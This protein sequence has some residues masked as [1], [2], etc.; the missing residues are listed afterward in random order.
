MSEETEKKQGKHLFQPGQS[1]NP[2]GRPKGARSKLQENFLAVL[3]D[4]FA[5]E[6]PEAVRR[7][8]E[9]TPAAYVK[10]IASLMPK[11]LEIERPLTDLSDDELISAVD[12]LRSF[13]AAQEVREGTG[14]PQ[15]R[16]PADTVQ[17]LH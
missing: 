8:R 17:A 13:L 11:T 16:E 15:G 6:G 1:G 10:A 2:A 9:E 14:N 7:M 5:A 4:D 12:S 3:A